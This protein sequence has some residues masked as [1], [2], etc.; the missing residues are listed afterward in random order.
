MHLVGW[1]ALDYSRQRYIPGGD[2]SRQRHQRQVIKAI[3]AKIISGGWIIAPSRA[4]D[5]MASL[6]QTLIFDGRGR[7]PSEFMYALRNLRPDK[8][9]TVG[10]PGNGVYS[11]GSYLGENLLPIEGPFFAALRSDTLAA[12]LS[13]N[14]SLLNPATAG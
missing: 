11:G 6:G 12:F 13:A 9:T 1:Q 7:Q 4:V 8:V 5:L 10:L 2:Y 3:M 14:P